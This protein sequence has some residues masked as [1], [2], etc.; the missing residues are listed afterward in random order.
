MTIQ[1]YAESV[2]AESERDS[3]NVTL[4]GVDISLLLGQFSSEQLL[5]HIAED[6]Y[7]SI[8]NYVAEQH[9]E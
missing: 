5:E 8:I 6:D 3:M 9:D 2:N 1:V 4:D 7:A